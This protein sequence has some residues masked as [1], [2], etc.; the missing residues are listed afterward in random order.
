MAD[1]QRPTVRSRKLGMMLRRIREDRNLSTHAAARLLNRSQASISKLETGHRGIHR[2]SLENMLDRYGVQDEQLRETLFRLAREARQKGW[3]Q[4]Y[5]GTLSPED[6][7]FIGLEADS[8]SIR[9]FE[10]ILIPGLLQTEAYARALIGQG[11]FSSD[12]RLVDRLVEI[13]MKRQRV[14]TRPEPPEVCAVLDEAALRR[15]VGGPEVMRAQLRHLIEA[16]HQPR[17]SLQVL[18]FAAGSYLG[19]AGAFIV[20]DVGEHGHF[21]VAKIDSLTEMSYREEPQQVRT[22]T[23]IFDRLRANALPE[24]DTRALIEGLLSNP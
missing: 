16:S 1:E 6:M 12:L 23:A 7:D 3:W 19:M 13:R 11:G 15:Q 24:A 5:G 9:F 17:V 22:Y 2:P 8:A 21:Q 18:P 20:M 4:S 10:L 14:L